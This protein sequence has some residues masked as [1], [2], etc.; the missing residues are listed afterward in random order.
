[1]CVRCL[2]SQI[3][4]DPLGDFRRAKKEIDDK[5]ADWQDQVT[6]LNTLRSLAKFNANV[7]AESDVH[8]LVI[9]IC[10]LCDSPRSSLSK[11]AISALGDMFMFSPK[12]LENEVP[13]A[14]NMLL[15]KASESSVFLNESVNTSLDV[16]ISVKLLI[17]Q[18][19]IQN[20]SPV[21]T[22]G[23]IIVGCQHKNPHVRARASQYLTRI[24]GLYG[25][26]VL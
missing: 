20:V 11:V 14:L 1:M 5:G 9:G 21:K 13:T 16:C 23:S 17:Q 4:R 3:V 26:K 24:V 12:V 8:A 18:Y 25:Q 2:Y 6:G 22:L 10:N 19:I 15:K 7:I